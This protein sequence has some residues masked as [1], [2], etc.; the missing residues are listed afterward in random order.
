MPVLSAQFASKRVLVVEDNLDSVHSLVLLLRDMGHRVEYA[1]NGYAA[2]DVARKFRPEIVFMDL[3][4]PGLDGFE[5]CG[6]L[7]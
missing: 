6:R 2:L 5:V 4:L 7:K 1:I 3:G